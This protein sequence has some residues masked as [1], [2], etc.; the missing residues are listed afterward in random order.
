MGTQNWARLGL[1]VVLL[2]VGLGLL[3]VAAERTNRRFDL[4]PTGTL[5]LAPLTRQ[6]LA[7]V[8]APLR[9]TVFYHRGTRAQYVDLLER[10]RAENPRVE[11]ALL[12]ID[13][14]PERARGLG[15]T[16][17]GRAAIEY[18]G[19]QA[20]VL[21]SPEAELAGGILRVLRGS[22]R[23]VGFTT[24]HG[25]RTPGGDP[26]DYGRLSSAL[27]AENY[28]P[29]AVSLQGGT[30]PSGIEVLVVAGPRHDFLPEELDAVARYLKAGGGV[31]MLLDPGPLPNLSRL[32]ADMG[33]RLGDDFVVDRTRRILGTDG[34]AA[35][36]ELFK[37]GNPVSD[38][39]ASPI[40]TGVVLPSAR[41][42]DVTRDVPGIEAQSIART[43]TTAWAMADPSRARR[44]E[45]P[46]EAARDVSGSL[47]LVVMA[48]VGPED[49]GNGRRR[50][51]LVVIG[52]AD[53]ASDAYLDLLGNRD[54][55][56]N[57]LAWIAGEPVLAGARDRTVPE[58][59][60]P[61]SPL[62][63]TERQARAVFVASVVAQPGAVLLGGLLWVGRRRRRG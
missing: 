30:V 40:E 28:A 59:V 8:T 34:L 60:R 54:L 41:T 24:G 12:D 62:V 27:A 21:A 42:V 19:R 57:A 22:T 16:R 2:L 50:G 7:Q 46:S 48:Q 13:R 4:T 36:V 52:D 9:I 45:T 38:P 58:I 33:L 35:V 56:L 43:A 25:E 17:Y 15:V 47:S 18:E 55:V 51:R 49:D 20:V 31:L 39:P 61:L 14:F 5:S 6:I 11:I 3:Q 63:L 29:E 53:L 32:L 37:Q 23:R 44:G 1:H 26:E 10:V